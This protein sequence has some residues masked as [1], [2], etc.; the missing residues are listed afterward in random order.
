LIWSSKTYCRDK[1]I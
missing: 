1:S